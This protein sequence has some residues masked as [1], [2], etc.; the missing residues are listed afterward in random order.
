MNN[1][2]PRAVIADDERLMREQL[3]ARL[4]EAWPELQVVAEADTGCLPGRLV[5]G[6]TK[7]GDLGKGVEVTGLER[8]VLAV[9]GEAQQLEAHAGCQRVGG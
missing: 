1:P 9:V 2:A 6:G 7:E 4:A 5:Q 3:R 8:G